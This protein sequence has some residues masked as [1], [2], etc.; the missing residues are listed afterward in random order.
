MDFFLAVNC[1]CAQEA[2]GRRREEFGGRGGGRGEAFPARGQITGRQRKSRLSQPCGRALPAL[3]GLSPG[4]ARGRAREGGGRP[5]AAPGGLCLGWLVPP[6]QGIPPPWLC[7]LRG[8][9][10]G[11]QS[12][13]RGQK[14]GKLKRG[15][16]GSPQLPPPRLPAQQAE[17]DAI[18]A[19]RFP[20]CEVRSQKRLPSAKERVRRQGTAIP[21]WRQERKLDGLSLSLD[22]C[23]PPTPLYPTLHASLLMRA[24]SLAPSSHFLFQKLR[25]PSRAGNAC[26]LHASLQEA[27]L[28]LP[29]LH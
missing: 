16:A 14:V 7:P 24:P 25:P 2:E 28:A 27:S 6:C 8:M 23:P 12:V 9:G 20:C 10:W 5:G 4:K 22:T 26:G 1:V 21:Q 3:P 11:W 19:L 17:T 18:R 13:R 15:E 29:T